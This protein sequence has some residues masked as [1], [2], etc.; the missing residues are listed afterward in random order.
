V[1][2]STAITNGGTAPTYQWVV[3]G[4]NVGSG[5]TS[6]SY[7]PNNMDSVR[8][9]LTSNA[10]CPLPNPVSSSAINIAVDTFA[11]PVITVAAPAAALVGSTVTVN[12]TV[13]GAGSSY[14]ITW[15]DNGIIFN[16]T[17]IPT[18]TYTKGTGTD[19]ISAWVLSTSPT[20]CYEKGFSD[21][22]IVNVDES[23]NNITG[24]G[25]VYV[26]PNPANDVLNIKTVTNLTYSI[27]NMLGSTIL[28][29]VL[30]KGSNSVSLQGLASGVYV[31]VLKDKESNRNI[32]KLVKE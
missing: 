5:A 30:E 29:G 17:T 21:T 20:G 26:Y 8:C 9:I 22:A 27:Q 12:A 3:N 7:T 4:A 6:Y 19:S 14:N 10:V 31:L 13:S 25:G 2:F 15:L 16:T 1:S 18:V 11:I 24:N 32:I 23:V 28:Q